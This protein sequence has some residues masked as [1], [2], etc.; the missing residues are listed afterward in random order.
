M[1]LPPLGGQPFRFVS[2][3][4]WPSGHYTEFASPYWFAPS[5]PPRAP[6]SSAS[7]AAHA[8]RSAGTSCVTVFHISAALILR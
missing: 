1:N 4:G 3:S 7:A 2:A 8:V 5:A 6:Y